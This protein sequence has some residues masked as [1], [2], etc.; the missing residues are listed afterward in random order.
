MTQSP[1]PPNADYVAV[2]SRARHVTPSIGA[3]AGIV[4][5]A[6]FTW[7]HDL[8]ISDIWNTLPA[9]SIAGAVSGALI[10]WSHGRLF[11]MPTAKNWF[12]YNMLHVA[13]LGILAVTSVALFDPVTTFA[14][15]VAANAPPRELM[16]QALPLSVAFAIGTSLL[17]YTLWGRGLLDAL[18]SLAASSALMILLGANVSV[19]GLVEM[20]G[21][22]YRTVALFFALIVLLA[23]VF[24]VSAIIAGHRRSSFRRHSAFTA[25][26]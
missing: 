1:A 23:V 24:S 5:T 10:A 3:V 18:A 22:A 13:L 4:S 11:R 12:G 15:V 25:P 8:T 14:A 20:P 7:V 26:R 21:S 2:T 19:L 6:V 9:M 16:A 17:L